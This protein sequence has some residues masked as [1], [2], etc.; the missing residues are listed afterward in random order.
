MNNIK[1]GAFG[2]LSL[3][4]IVGCSN[5]EV[6]APEDSNNETTD[7]I[8]EEQQAQ[9]EEEQAIDENEPETIRVSAVGDVIGHADLYK[10]GDPN[11]DDEYNYDQMFKY[12]KPLLE[13]SE[14]SIAN[15]ETTLSS[16]PSEYR[17]YPSF[18]T[19]KE[20]I[21]GLDYAGFDA[22]ITANNH[23][24]DNFA[25]GAIETVELVEE[26]KLPAIGTSTDSESERFYIETINGIDIGV[27]AFTSFVNGEESGMFTTEEIHQH[28]NMLEEEIIQSEIEAVKEFDPDIILAYAHWG[29][30]YTTEL[31]AEQEHFAQVFAELGVDAVIG[32]HPHV[33]QE[34]DIITHDDHEMFIIYSVGNFLSNQR[35]ESLGEDF[36]Q[37]EDGVIVHLDY[38]F[39]EDA[40]SV[41]L[42]DVNFTP[43]WVKRETID[44]GI[45]EYA[46]LPA[47]LHDDESFSEDTRERMKDSYDR[48]MDHLQFSY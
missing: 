11:Q 46:V 28:V 35:Y 4:T 43:T 41:E 27:V 48:T 2:I 15:L 36:R 33:V 9:V 32:S 42:T 26:Q 23:S 38:T 20:L 5:D 37:T 29:D 12:V 21:E 3:L 10:A 40:D 17:G 25:N 14:F 34:A 1:K 44:D 45:Y 47:E 8:E 30:E 24:M 6:E 18:V 16:D 31:S 7:Q 39:S 22:V 13:E 19:P